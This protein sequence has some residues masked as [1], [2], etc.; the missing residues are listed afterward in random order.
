MP[1]VKVFDM[2]GKQTGEIA[3][4]EKL[5]GAEIHQVFQSGIEHFRDQH[6]TDQQQQDR[7]LGRS[8]P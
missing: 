8:K 2:A 4:S 7:K 1:N 3:L 6:K 5:F